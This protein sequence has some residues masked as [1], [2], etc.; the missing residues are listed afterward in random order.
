MKEGIAGFIVRSGIIA[1]DFVQFFFVKLDE[2]LK[3]G[4]FIWSRHGKEFMT[5]AINFCSLSPKTYQPL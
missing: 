4:K 2:A 1:R 3:S 5:L